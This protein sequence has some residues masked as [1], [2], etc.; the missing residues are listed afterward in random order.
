ML[1]LLVT[2]TI[3]INGKRTMILPNDFNGPKTFSPLK[4]VRSEVSVIKRS[5]RSAPSDA[6]V[7]FKHDVSPLTQCLGEM[8]SNPDRATSSSASAG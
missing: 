6:D 5:V 4:L 7:H 2:I 8:S 1:I 3:S